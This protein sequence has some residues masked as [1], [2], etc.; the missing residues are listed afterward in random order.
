MPNWRPVRI[1]KS[2]KMVLTANGELPTKEEATVDVKE[3]DFFVTVVLLEDTT[4][5]LSFG[6]LCEEFGYSYHWTS[7]Q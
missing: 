3:L 1:S 7:G 5:V 4:A 6:K 2:P